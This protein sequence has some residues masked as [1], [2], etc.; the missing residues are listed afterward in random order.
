MMNIVFAGGGTGGHIYPGLAVVDELR[1]KLDVENAGKYRIIWI[2]SKN[3][4]D[5]D[6]VDKSG[7]IDK[8]VGIPCGKLRR[9]FSFKNLVDFFKIA[10]GFVSAFF[11]LLKYKPVMLFSKG[12]FVSVPPCFSAKALRIPVFTHEC[13]FSPGLATRLNSRC[14]TKILVSFEKTKSFFSGAK[15]SKVVVSG[16]PVR[17]VFYEADPEK[18]LRFLGLEN[19]GETGGHEKPLLLVLGG[20]LGAVQI[21][22]L[23]YDNIDWLCENFTVVHQTGKADI[24]RFTGLKSSHGGYYPYPFIYGEMP[25]VMVAA[26]VVLSR[27]GSN[28]LWECSVT[29]RPLVLIPLAGS[30]TRGDQVENARFFE[31]QGAAKVLTG[32][33]VTAEKLKTVLSEMKD[34]DVRENLS[35]NV[36]K[37]SKESRPALTIANLM[38]DEIQNKIRHN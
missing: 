32:E 5:K 31:S 29:G 18:G 23:I 28:F 36:R 37:M 14:A 21:N 26:D 4:L 7:S 1:K 13:D 22:N 35:E 6:I 12:G 10:A 24:D 15:A 30:G 38:F 11:I 20:S 25:D 19:K 16:N 17:P 33:D 2:G 8:F 3:K 34:A 27:A 9:Y